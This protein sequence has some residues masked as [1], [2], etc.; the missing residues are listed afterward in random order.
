LGVAE[1][2]KACDLQLLAQPASLT[3]VE[4]A[5][6][7]VELEEEMAETVEEAFRCG[8]RT[9]LEED[10][11][12]TQYFRGVEKLMAA[13]DS[14]V[15]LLREAAGSGGRVVEP[16]VEW[17]WLPWSRTEEGGEWR[18]I[19]ETTQPVSWR[20]VVFGKAGQWWG[21]IWA[22]D[23][24]ERASLLTYSSPSNADPEALKQQL[25]RRLGLLLAALGTGGEG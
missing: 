24:E 8:Q 4:G 2:R 23:I 20:L 16:V 1:L 11:T 6:S 10:A 3:P 25:T 12:N 9:P 5:R 17:K 13:T 22:V 21:E 7:L 14:A 15:S 18:T 19:S